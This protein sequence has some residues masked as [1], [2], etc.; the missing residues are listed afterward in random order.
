MVYV[1]LVC[2]VAGLFSGLYVKPEVA[3]HSIFCRHGLLA[4]AFIDEIV[5]TNAYEGLTRF[6]KNGYIKPLLAKRWCINNDGTVF[7][8]TLHQGV[9]FHD[10][11]VLTSDH[12]K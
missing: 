6:D 3:R 7:R 9:R 12:V 10:G 5:Y 2:L 4:P 8:F 11:E 1:L